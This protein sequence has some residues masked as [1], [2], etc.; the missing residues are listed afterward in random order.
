MSEADLAEDLRTAVGDFVR[1]MR[2][3]DS[4]PPGQAAV[5]GHLDRSGALTIT[6]LARREHVRHQSMTRTIGLLAEQ[7]LI[8]LRTADH[9]RRRVL[10]TITDAGTERLAVERE[11]RTAGIAR[12]IRE[13]L[14]PDEREIISRIPMILRKLGS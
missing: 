4:M 7:D 5:L 10:A 11:R 8:G 3:A 1:R 9:D 6:E 12:A 13:D 2:A 14:D